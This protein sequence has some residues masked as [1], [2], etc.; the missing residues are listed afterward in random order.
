MAVEHVR[1]MTMV[2]NASGIYGIKP[3][4]MKFHRILSV[5]KRG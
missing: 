3:Q 5:Y 2:R 1:Y 4:Q